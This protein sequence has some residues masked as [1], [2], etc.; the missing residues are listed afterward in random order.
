MWCPATQVTTGRLR[1]ALPGGGGGL[2]GHCEPAG[3]RTPEPHAWGGS[4]FWWS[5]KST[6]VFA[7]P[8]LRSTACEQPDGEVHVHPSRG[9]LRTTWW[10]AARPAIE[11]DPS[12]AVVACG[13]PEA[14]LPFPLR[15]THTGAPAPRG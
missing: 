2:C 7:W 13:S 8:A 14:G 5:P 10:P 9:A 4:G 12:A 1:H 3:T 6:P 11:Y 15:A